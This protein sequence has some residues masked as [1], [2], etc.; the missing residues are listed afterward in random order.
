MSEEIKQADKNK[1]IA[2]GSP[3][4]TNG[5]MSLCAECREHYINFPIPNKIK[6]AAAVIILIVIFSLITFPTQINSVA[7]LLKAKKAIEQKEFVTAD[8]HLTKYLSKYPEHTEANAYMLIS[9]Y[10]NNDIEKLS[11]TYQILLDKKI[12]DEDL[13]KQLDT[14]MQLAIINFESDSLISYVKKMDST[15]SIKNKLISYLHVNPTDLSASYF[16]ANAYLSDKDYLGAERLFDSLHHEYPNSI[17][18]LDGLV[19]V[20]RLLKKNDEALHLCNQALLINKQF[21]SIIAQ[22]ART[23]IAMNKDAASLLLSQKAVALKPKDTYALTTLAI[24]YHYNNNTNERNK[25]MSSLKG[26]MTAQD[27]F[28]VNMAKDIF[29]GKDKLR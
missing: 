2:C 19:S 3:Y 20:K 7:S 11:K 17:E 21:V 12:E 18:F 10:Y 26:N 5:N 14:V 23:L 22:K 15:I 28:Y 25:I 13:F 6:I 8:K 4:I 16:L 9:S 29:S 1:C 27:S 24:A